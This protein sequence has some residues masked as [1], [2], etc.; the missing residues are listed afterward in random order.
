MNKMAQFFPAPHPRRLS[1]NSFPST[2]ALLGFLTECKR[3]SHV[4]V[5]INSIHFFSM[6]AK[7]I[8]C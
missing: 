1:K 5:K 6:L 2:V 7:V 4:L 3:L 8:F